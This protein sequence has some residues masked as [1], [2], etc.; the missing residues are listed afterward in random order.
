MHSKYVMVDKGKRTSISSVNFSYTSFIKNREA[1]VVLEQC[2]CPTIAFYKSVFDSDW[3]T[4]SEYF[5]TNNYNKSQLDYIKNTSSMGYPPLPHY[6]VP[7]AYVTPLKTYD[8]VMVK[9]GYTSPDN[10]RT[11]IM[12]QLKSIKSSL[13]VGNYSA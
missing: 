9:N 12:D 5:I 1:G 4:A 3:A 13:E 10:A 11:T 6:V 7:G 2:D 8:A